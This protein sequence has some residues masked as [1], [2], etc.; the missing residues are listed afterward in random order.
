MPKIITFIKKRETAIKIIFFLSVS[1]LVVN[2]FS[3]LLKTISINDILSNFKDLNP[4]TLMMMLVLGLIG[5]LPMLFYDIIL[6]KELETHFPLRSI[7]ETSWV[8]NSFNNIIGFAGIVDVG[9]R[10]TFYS[11][12]KTAETSLTKITSVLPYF[13]TGFSL[14]S[15]V[16][17][18]ILAVSQQDHSL[19]KY[20]PILVVISLYLP[21]VLVLSVKK[22]AI[23]GK[24]K[25][26][27]LL[28]L[29]VASFGDWLTV[30]GGFICIGMLL[31]MK[32][33]VVAI[34]PLVVIG[35]AAGMAS[36]IPGGVGSFDL[37]MLTGLVSLG[38]VQKA[39]A[40]AWLLMFRICYY[41]IPFIIGVIFFI[42]HMGSHFA[43]QY[44]GIPSKLIKV[45]L[46]Q[47]QLV[48]I[49]LFGFFL[50][51]SALIPEKIQAIPL[52]NDINPVRAQIL[53]QYPSIVLGG[54]F[55]LLARLLA[56]RLRIALP[57]AYI[58]FAITICYINLV[59]VALFSSTFLILSFSLVWLK[60]KELNRKV[61][62]YSW[63]SKTK[64][65]V[66]FITTVL[67]L[68]AFIGKSLTLSLKHIKASKLEDYLEI[69]VQIAFLAAIT[70]LIYKGVIWLA[71]RQK[72]SLGEAFD[73]ERFTRLLKV[74][75]STSGAGLA[76]L[77]NKKLFWYQKD[78]VDY[79]VL[80]FSI[81]QNKCVVMG[82]PIGNK[83]FYRSALTAFVKACQE[84]NMSAIFYEISQET[85]L[86]LHDLGFDFIKFGESAQVDLNTFSLEGK[87][88]KKYRLMSHKLENKGYSFD[89]YQPPHS[90]DLLDQLE[91]ISNAWLDGRRERGFSLGYF[92]RD[93]LQL[94]PIAVVKN[95]EGQLL[96]FANFLP[97]NNKEM[98]TIDL[99]RYRL[100]DAPNGIMDYLFVK[101]FDYFKSENVAYFDLGMAP[102]ANVG[103]LEHSFLQEK[104]AYFIYLFSK[105]FY[106]FEGLHQYKQKFRPS[107]TPR[108]IS[109]SKNDWLLY[110]MISIYMLG[111][112]PVEKKLT[113]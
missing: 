5:V 2:E 16:A 92:N 85:T 55:I 94:A 54:L 10:Y 109:Y 1:I 46:D 63:E 7:L 88:S 18:I 93:Y 6:N 31:G 76:F 58:L 103:N 99:M 45:F 48:L 32:V 38:G 51:L 105:R 57:I 4:I 91:E 24:L 34:L 70:L 112:Q 102:L 107:W 106:S 41:I 49:R 65:M 89:V 96:A 74:Y 73:K 11:E 104:L 66:L 61:F 47:T 12:D 69:W 39:E 20:W 40:L 3:H 72:T 30:V 68:I 86:I 95:G 25:P 77:G 23:F 84:D 75:G 60:R 15:F 83:S 81:Y 13:G 27:S 9:L 101:L 43:K 53:W 100:Q 64:D 78:T 21:I 26:S 14:F 98:A 59:T 62:T 71:S 87:N 111:N 50:I 37:V 97:I 17:L 35:H 28:T 113:L 19:L 79:V 80:Q 110:D 42:K 67:V 82:D 22:I 36:M 8:I 33:H 108:Y 29:L 90:A 44:Y 56:N 52:L